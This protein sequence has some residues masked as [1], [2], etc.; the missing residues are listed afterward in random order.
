MRL[1]KENAIFRKPLYVRRWNRVPVGFNISPGIVGVQ[2][3]DVGLG[4]LRHSVM[5]LSIL[6]GVGLADGGPRV[7]DALAV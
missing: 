4:H 5:V 7:Q 1:M 2:I 6:Y 3:K